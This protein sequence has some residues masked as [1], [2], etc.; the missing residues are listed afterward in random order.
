MCLFPKFHMY[1]KGNQNL[2]VKMG[3]VS[4]LLQAPGRSFN[5]AA[6]HARRPR[7]RLFLVA[8][9]AR[10][11]NAVF[12]GHCW[13]DESEG[14]RVNHGVGWPFRF[15]RGHVAGDALASRVTFFVMDVFFKSSRAG[16]VRRCRTVTIQAKL[17]GWL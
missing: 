16:A 9:G 5:P 17:V 7:R 4:A 3:M 12:F 1:D 2:R 14:V 10:I 8:S 6:H 13:G 11:R 15:N